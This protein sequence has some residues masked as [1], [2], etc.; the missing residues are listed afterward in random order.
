MVPNRTRAFHAVDSSRQRVERQAGLR[1]SSQS[2]RV[3]EES[4][5]NVLSAGSAAGGRRRGP[6]ASDSLNAEPGPRRVIRPW[7]AARPPM[8]ALPMLKLGCPH[9]GANGSG[10]D[11][12]P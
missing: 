4:A 2:Q 6:G 12:L 3:A 5:P 11:L 10:S 1:S 9:G 7:T 8:L